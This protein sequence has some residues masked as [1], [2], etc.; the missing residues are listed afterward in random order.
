MINLLANKELDPSS[1]LP[2]YHCRRLPRMRG[3]G[4][5][6]QLAAVHSICGS[7]L[8]EHVLQMLKKYLITDLASFEKRI[9]RRREGSP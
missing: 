7:S 8:D 4:R 2:I 3:N 6:P 5:A 9:Y 1:I